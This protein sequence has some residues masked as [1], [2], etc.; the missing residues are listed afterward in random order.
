MLGLPGLTR[1]LVLHLLAGTPL[2]VSLT[3]A[4]AA[5]V[6]AAGKHAAAVAATA[7]LD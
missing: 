2:I 7:E 5:A 3:A 6:V 4:A 1:V